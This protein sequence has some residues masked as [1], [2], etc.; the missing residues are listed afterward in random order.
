V[1]KTL[2]YFG[3]ALL[4]SFLPFQASAQTPPRV[5]HLLVALAD[6]VHQGIVPVPS[7]LGN[8]DDPA[9]IF[10][11]ARRLASGRFSKRVRIG[12]RLQ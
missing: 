3:I 1:G 4:I 10:T 6:N 7:A 12:N 8:G 2:R 9:G 5:V 11:G